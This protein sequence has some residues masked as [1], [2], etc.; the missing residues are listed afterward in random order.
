M[1]HKKCTWVVAVIVVLLTTVAMKSSIFANDGISTEQASQQTG[2]EEIQTAE[3]PSAPSA[4]EGEIE[5]RGG[6]PLQQRPSGPMQMVIPWA[7]PPQMHIVPPP[8][9]LTWQQLWD[10]TWQATLSHYR[11]QAAP[12]VLHD[13]VCKG[14]LGFHLLIRDTITAMTLREYGDAL[15]FMGVFHS[16]LMCLSRE[17]VRG[18]EYALSSFA[19]QAIWELS[20]SQTIIAVHG[21]MNLGMLTFDQLQYTQR[22]WW[23]PTLVFHAYPLGPIMARYPRQ[24]LGFWVFDEESNRLT[25]TNSFNDI[26]R[27][28]GSMQ[29]PETFGDFKCSLMQMSKN[30]FMCP[31]DGQGSGGKGG[32]PGKGGLPGISAPSSAVSCVLAAANDAGMRGQMQCLQRAVTG[33]KVSPFTTPS[34]LLNPAPSSSGIRDKLCALSD[35]EGDGTNTTGN[36]E[37][38]PGGI[39]QTIQSIK[40]K[41][42]ET[43]QDLQK[44]WAEVKEFVETAVEKAKEFKDAF[45][46]LPPGIRELS[47]LAS[48]EGANAE[49]GL[50]N[51]FDEVQRKGDLQDTPNLQKGIEKYYDD[52]QNKKPTDPGSY[53]RRTVEDFGGRSGGTGCGSGSN[54][55]ARARSLYQCFA[56]KDP[57]SPGSGGV[58]ANPPDP[59]AGESTPEAYMACKKSS[60]RVVGIGQGPQPIDPTIARI[61]PDVNP[62]TP[63]PLSVQQTKMPAAMA[64]AVQGGDMPRMSM[65][66]SQCAAMRCVEGAVCPCN[67]TASLGANQM[68]PRQP[69]PGVIDCAPTGEGGPGLGP[70]EQKPTAP[71]TVPI[72]PGGGGPTP[73]QGPGGGPPGVK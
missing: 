2:Q 1:K 45:K 63:G 22:S 56:G 19:T 3:Q 8:P 42:S 5:T 28:I 59:C 24:E 10:R 11:I 14:E 51:T 16:K 49:A 27:L 21:V 26:D 36:E 20:P 31:Q 65:N 70:C 13:P 44:K 48:E 4:T 29:R 43:A 9:P 6:V 64:C 12:T 34:E 39:K 30:A 17:G 55:A 53:K 41:A 7:I 69:R 54:A 18:I 50:K 61:E 68:Q 71:G 52:R 62:G 60:N 23:M 47:Q 58:R 67:R 25:R 15:R 38:K 57:R 35:N 32:Q 40:N 37:K 33:V 73:G 46:R 66:D 72:P